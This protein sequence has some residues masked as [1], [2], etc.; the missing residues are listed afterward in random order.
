MSASTAVLPPNAD[1]VERLHQQLRSFA[2]VLG[3]DPDAP[4]AVVRF[5]AALL[6]NLS[7][8][9]TTKVQ[10]PMKVRRAPTWQAGLYEELY[11]DVN[12]VK[13]RQNCSIRAAIRILCDDKN[14]QWGNAAGKRKYKWQTLEQRYHEARDWRRD[15]IARSLME[16]SSR[17][18]PV[19]R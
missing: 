9:T 11:R 19:S 14:T 2:S 17:N 16:Q 1:E 10:K 8:L 12:E 3:V 13:F 18:E 4:D 15:R 5:T 6:L 7:L